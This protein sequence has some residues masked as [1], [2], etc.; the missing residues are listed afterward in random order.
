[1]KNALQRLID[2]WYD[3]YVKDH[4]KAPSWEVFTDKVNEFKF[5]LD[6]D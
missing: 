6:I 4:S 5:L 2:E 1:M 3:K